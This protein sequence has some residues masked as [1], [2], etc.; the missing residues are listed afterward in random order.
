VGSFALP[1]SQST[2]DGNTDA[3]APHGIGMVWNGVFTENC[4]QQSIIAQVKQGHS[5]ISEAPLIHIAL[6]EARMGDEASAV[7]R[8]G[9]LGIT[10]ADSRGLNSIAI[11]A[12]GLKYCTNIFAATRHGRAK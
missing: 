4:E 1:G 9:E 3:H 11:I 8:Q 7:D 6:G 2:R 5:F 12:D 10:I